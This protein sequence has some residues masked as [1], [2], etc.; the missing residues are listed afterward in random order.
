MKTNGHLRRGLTVLTLIFVL[1]LGQMMFLSP[2]G[3][4]ASA[5]ENEEPSTEEQTDDTAGASEELFEHFDPLPFEPVHREANNIL[6]GSG[7]VIAVLIIGGAV[8]VDNR[9]QN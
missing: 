7:L 5:T 1:T 9:R 4:F 3:L 6:L 8:V 2:A